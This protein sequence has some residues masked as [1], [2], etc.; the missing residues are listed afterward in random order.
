MGDV[1][2][3]GT[4]RKDAFSDREKV[5]WAEAITMCC[6]QVGISQ[7]PIDLVS[8]HYSSIGIRA[9]AKKMLFKLVDKLHAMG[10]SLSRLPLVP[11]CLKLGP[12]VGR[13]LEVRIGSP[14]DGGATE[15]WAV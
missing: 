9:L 5:T 8:G 6:G 1:C 12:G 2:R 4:C 15:G 13:F 3:P 10:K 14:A 11:Q 7:I